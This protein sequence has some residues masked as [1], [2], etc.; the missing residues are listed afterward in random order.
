MNPGRKTRTQNKKNP[1]KNSRK[2]NQMSNTGPLGRTQ[3]A[4]AARTKVIQTG[5]AKVNNLPN[6]DVRVVHREFLQEV[7]NVGTNFQAALVNINPGLVTT[8]PWLSKIARNFESYRFNRLKFDYETESS[9][10]S[11]GCVMLAVDYD[12]SDAAPA[13]KQQLMAY[14]RSVRSA[15][16]QPCCHTSEKEDLNKQK[17]YFVRSQ[18]LLANL[19]QKLYDTGNF[20]LA[21]QNLGGTAQGEIYIEYDITLMTPELNLTEIVGGSVVGGGT[22]SAATPLG[23]APVPDAQNFGI[24]VGTTANSILTFTQLG[25]YVLT[26]A[27]VG[28]V[29][30]AAPSAQILGAGVT[31]LN[32]TLGV[33]DSGALNAIVRSEVRVS[34][35]TAATIGIQLSATTITASRLDVAIAP[36]N[37]LA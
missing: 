5:R 23:N 20:I 34:S 4:P 25:D 10:A 19:D 2:N 27:F 8:F 11:A 36:T 14:R 6:G 12:V 18:P 21:T 9:S 32:S 16:W 35:L 17:T 3:F 7:A 33:I 28:T 15:V 22:L 31:L 1:A 30:A 29:I 26:Y 37:S 13:S 24:T